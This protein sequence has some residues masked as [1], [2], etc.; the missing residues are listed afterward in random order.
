MGLGTP[1]GSL[2]GRGVIADFK[3]TPHRGWG[4][5]TSLHV[6]IR[7]ANSAEF[8][9]IDPSGSELDSRARLSWAQRANICRKGD[10]FTTLAYSRF[11][12]CE[13]GM[14]PASPVMSSIAENKSV[15]NWT[16]EHCC[17]HVLAEVPNTFVQACSANLG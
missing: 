5:K 2:S 10:G 13:V 11:R 16:G 9:Q 12:E 4:K 14:L 7:H 1:G 15:G 17:T 3:T 6:G 8:G